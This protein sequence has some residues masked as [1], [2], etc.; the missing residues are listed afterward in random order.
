MHILRRWLLMTVFLLASC[1]FSVRSEDATNAF[2]LA[3]NHEHGINVQIDMEKAAFYYRQ[4]AEGG[5]AEAQFNLGNLYLAG[6]GVALNPAAAVEWF[7]KAA[8][9]GLPAAQYNLANAYRTGQ[10]VQQDFARALQWYRNAADRGMPQAQYNLGAM[11][12]NGEGVPQDYAQ[13]YYW[14]LL[15]AKQGY[16]EAHAYLDNFRPDLSAKTRADIE[17]EVER[18]RASFSQDMQSLKDETLTP[19]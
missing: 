11:Y 12:G 9:Q 14:L 7:R 17:R 13:A 3:Y 8:E 2:Q 4:A 19:R 16:S 10:G 1:S 15:S 6:S 5:L 18:V